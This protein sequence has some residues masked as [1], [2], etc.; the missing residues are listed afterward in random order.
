ME[1][2]M[3]LIGIALS[4][5]ESFYRDELMRSSSS[6]KVVRA[7]LREGER[8]LKLLGK[9]SLDKTLKRLREV[10]EDLVGL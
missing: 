5:P 3:R 1:I 6:R 10:Q 9:G 4:E 7:F 2:L 8:L